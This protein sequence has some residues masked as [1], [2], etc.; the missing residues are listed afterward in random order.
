MAVGTDVL[1]QRLIDG[2]EREIAAEENDYAGESY[3][4]RAAASARRTARSSI[5]EKILADL[6]E[7]LDAAVADIRRQLEEDLEDLYAGEEGSG[8]SSG[9]D[10]GEAPYEV[11]YTLPMSERYAEVKAYYL[12]YEDKE[13]ALADYREDKI[14]EDYL[15]VYYNYLLQLLMTQV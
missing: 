3:K 7:K 6:K 12:A 15:G 4:A 2:A 14:A 5:L 1:A 8:P 13:E 10:P 9:I 11:D